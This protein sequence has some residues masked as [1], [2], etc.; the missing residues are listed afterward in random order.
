MRDSNQNKIR[1]ITVAFEEFQGSSED[2]APLAAQVAKYYGAS[3]EVRQVSEREFLDDLP[4]YST[5]WTSPRSMGVNT[6][7][8]C[9]GQPGNLGQGRNLWSGGDELLLGYPGLSRCHIGAGESVFGPR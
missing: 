9:Q 6:W 1:A 7:F 8:C 4:A 3:H 2:E 5:P